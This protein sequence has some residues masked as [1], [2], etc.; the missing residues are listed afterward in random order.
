[1]ALSKHTRGPWYV[2]DRVERY[3]ILAEGSDYEIASIE[4]GAIAEEAGRPSENVEA[5]AAVIGAAPDMYRLLSAV[6]LAIDASLASG[7]PID[8][9]RLVKLGTEIDAVLAKARGE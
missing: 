5:D 9:K 8:S 2:E 4:N 3:V 1:M 7:R 6:S